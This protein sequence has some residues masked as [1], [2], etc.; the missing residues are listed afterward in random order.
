MPSWFS[1]AVRG[2]GFGG[3]QGRPSTFMQGRPF[4]RLP[5]SASSPQPSPPPPPSPSPSASSRSPLQRRDPSTSSSGA[6]DETS[7]TSSGG[8]ARDVDRTRVD[9][10]AGE[11][12]RTDKGG[13]E[14][15]GSDWEVK[16]VVVGGAASGVVTGGVAL[17]VDIA[18]ARH[19]A[20]VANSVNEN[21][22]SSQATYAS[23]SKM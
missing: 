19:Q 4:S 3:P 17:S 13:G 10:D 2:F 14:K 11:T 5:D 8:Q 9:P 6:A 1:S 18:G 20:S 23:I 16:M 12:K 7:R 22:A 21:N 15:S